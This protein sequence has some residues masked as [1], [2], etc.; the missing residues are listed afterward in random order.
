LWTHLQKA[1]GFSNS[2]PNG[3]D[4]KFAF[5]NS[6]TIGSRTISPPNG[7]TDTEFINNMGAQFNNINAN[8]YG[9]WGLGN[10]PGI[11]DANS[12]NFAYTL[13]VCQQRFEFALEPA[14]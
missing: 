8:A 7:E 14:A 12:N 13:G 2:D 10:I 5:G 11:Y 9:Y 3:L 1:I 4:T 6:P